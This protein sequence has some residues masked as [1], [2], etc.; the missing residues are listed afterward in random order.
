[1]IHAKIQD[2]ILKFDSTAAKRTIA[3]LTGDGNDNKGRTSFPGVVEAA[4]RKGFS[5]EV[6]SWRAQCSKVYSKFQANYPRYF[7]LKY[8]DEHM[9]LVKVYYYELFA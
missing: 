5:V 6:W 9:Y 1:M 3:I 8:L 4:L 7:S 2:T